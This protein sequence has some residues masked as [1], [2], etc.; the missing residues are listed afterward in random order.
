M[1]TFDLQKEQIKRD[2][3][4]TKRQR[5]E[6]RRS[7]KARRET[8]RLYKRELAI[9]RFMKKT[10]VSISHYGKVDN[11]DEVV[12]SKLERL[13]KSRLSA[14]PESTIIHQEY[15]EYTKFMPLCHLGC[16]WDGEPFK[17]IYDVPLDGSYV[18]YVYDS[19]ERGLGAFHRISAIESNKEIPLVY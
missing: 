15:N 14:H 12:K 5:E 1:P 6:E 13:Y 7:R 9:L 17:T 8:D 19:G 3:Q 18:F 4:E 2:K 11:F 10:G 16:K